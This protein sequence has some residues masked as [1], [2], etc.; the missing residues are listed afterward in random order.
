[1]M[2]FKFKSKHTWSPISSFRLLA[3]ERKH[4]PLDT[5]TLCLC[6]H[7][8]SS[9]SSSLFLSRVFS[10]CTIIHLNMQSFPC[11]HSRGRAFPDA[12]PLRC[13]TA[14]LPFNLFN[15]ECHLL[16]LNAEPALSQQD[17]SLLEVSWLSNDCESLHHFFSPFPNSQT[18]TDFS[19]FLCHHTALGS[20]QWR[21]PWDHGACPPTSISAPALLPPFSHPGLWCFLGAVVADPMDLQGGSQGILGQGRPS[22][23]AHELSHC[24]TPQ[25][26]QTLLATFDNQSIFHFSLP[27]PIYGEKYPPREYLHCK[28]GQSPHRMEGVQLQDNFPLAT[29]LLSVI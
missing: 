3:F 1:M 26:S 17:A 20:F 29:C 22:S 24:C 7:F 9:D 4:V 11:L 5:V 10:L 25:A 14:H 13:L 16:F 28:W 27:L 6:M 23:Q 15:F 2:T 12:T 8:F 18:Q 19:F 21:H